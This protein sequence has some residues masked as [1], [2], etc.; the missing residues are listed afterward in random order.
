MQMSLH[1]FYV[2]VI[3]YKSANPFQRYGQAMFNHLVTVRPDL[4]EM[5]RGTN[6]DPFYCLSQTEPRFDKFTNFIEKCWY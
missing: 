6:C 3:A 1:Q 2:G 4:A 5:V